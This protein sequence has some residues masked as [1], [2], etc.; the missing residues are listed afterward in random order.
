MTST[1]DIRRSFLDYFGANGHEIVASAP[2]VPPSPLDSSG[3]STP[4]SAGLISRMA[5]PL[6][7][8]HTATTVQA[9]SPATSRRSSVNQ[10]LFANASGRLRV[11]GARHN[12][13][14]SSAAAADARAFSVLS[15]AVLASVPRP[16]PLLPDD[17]ALA[18]GPDTNGADPKPRVARGIFNM[19][20]TSAK[21]PIQVLAEVTRVL[22]HNKVTFTH[23]NMYT[24]E[25][26]VRDTAF[27]YSTVFSHS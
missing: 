12:R 26:E 7:R 6:L 3:A 27:V 17:H 4:P 18:T 20:T 13:S 11:P 10:H 2:L 9:A 8:S 22:R 25:C 1:N 16:P 5:A 14:R 19:D 15:A 24:F 21:H 23:E